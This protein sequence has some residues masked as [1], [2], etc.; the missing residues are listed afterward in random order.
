MKTKVSMFTDFFYHGYFCSHH[1]LYTYVIGSNELER[2]E[3]C[4]S[5]EKANVTSD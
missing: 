2:F 4:S 5:R 1:L 3:I